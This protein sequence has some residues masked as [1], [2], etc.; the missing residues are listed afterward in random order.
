MLVNGTPDDAGLYTGFMVAYR[1]CKNAKTDGKVILNTRHM[2]KAI[3]HRGLLHV[4]HRV[5]I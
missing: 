4:C 3:I 2:D 5:R 1:C